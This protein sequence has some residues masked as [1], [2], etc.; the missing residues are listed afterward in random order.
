[1]IKSL[2]LTNFLSFGPLAQP[3]PLEKLNIIIG[4]NGSGKSNVLEAVNLLKNAPEQIAKPIRESGGVVDWIWK[5]ED[6]AIAGVEV[7][8]YFLKV[9]M[10]YKISFQ[11]SIFFGG[12]AI[13]NEEFIG[14]SLHYTYQDSTPILKIKGETVDIN[15][16]KID[17]GRSFLSQF[18]L[19]TSDYFEVEV[20]SMR[21]SSIALYREWS[22]GRCTSPR[23]PQKADMPNDRL[24]AD[25][26]NLGLVL[27]RLRREPEA[28]RRLLEA[29]RVLYDG[30]DDFDV[31]IEGGTV[32]VFLQEG[33]FII[34]ATRLSDGTLRY[35]ALLAVLCDPNPPPLVCIE[36][37]ELGLH[38]DVVCS[39]GDLLREASERSQII[40]TTHSELLVDTFTDM[41]EVVLVC[42]KDENGSTL[43][44]LDPM[45]LKPW[46]ERY[47]LGDHWLR[48]GIGG[49]RW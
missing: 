6:N 34:P 30:I 41:P 14:K 29:L 43:N 45:E 40:V 9:P 42:E 2:K 47:R 24:E 5:G 48:G 13:I 21:L 31:R 16:E 26:S 3:I 19:P 36:E 25:A 32:Q 35:L 44:R 27:N 15:P 4:V 12:F 38:P 46:L 23:M 11:D 20:A 7:E 28:K 10:R 33:R 1:M 18:R 49:T 39:L 37:P 17:N 8:F 22:F